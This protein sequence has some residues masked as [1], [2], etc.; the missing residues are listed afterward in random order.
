MA[1]EVLGTTDDVGK[2]VID[3]EAL[4]WIDIKDEDSA[5][6]AVPYLPARPVIVEA[7]AC[8]CED[9][10]RFKELWPHSRIFTFEPNPDLYQKA[11]NNLLKSGQEGISLHPFAL[12]DKLENRTYY[13]SEFEGT[14]SFY[15]NN[16]ASVVYPDSI[17]KFLGL[18]NGGTV[19]T[20]AENPITVRCIT[21]DSIGVQ[22]DYI[23]LDV[24]GAELVALSGAVETLKK[25]RAVTL[26]MNHQEFR[27]GMV[28]FEDV[29]SFMIDHGFE[30]K[31]AWRAHKK[32][33]SNAMFVRKELA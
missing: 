12:S 14:S 8:V 23:W 21:I 24:E 19:P 2:G 10:L 6:L 15:P 1:D 4:P 26:E 33:Q 11:F 20:F 27:K 3:V 31:A 25:V 9:T 28:Q 22:V 29:Y 32:W 16:Q 17:R 30:I 7:G 13:A 5:Q 18:D